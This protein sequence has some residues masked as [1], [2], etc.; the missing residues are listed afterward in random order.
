MASF[1]NM[2]HDF[3]KPS[4]HQ[5]DDLT[6]NLKQVAPH[7]DAFDLA[8][9][10]DANGDIRQTKM[11]TFDTSI[12]QP[13]KDLL[14]H[15]FSLVQTDSDSGDWEPSGQNGMSAAIAKAK[16][17]D[18][19]AEDKADGFSASNDILSAANM[20]QE[21]SEL[22]FYQEEDFSGEDWT[23]AG[24]TGLSDAITKARQDT[25]DDEIRHDGLKGNGLLSAAGIAQ[26]EDEEEDLDLVSFVQVETSEWHPQDSLGESISKAR[27][28]EEEARA[29]NMDLEGNT[30]LSAAGIHTEEEKEVD[31]LET[32]FIQEDASWSPKGQQ[33]QKD[34][35]EDEEPK[36]DEHSVTKIVKQHSHDDMEGMNI[37]SAVGLGH[38]LR[39]GDEAD[40]IGRVDADDFDFSLD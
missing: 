15:A 11:A 3:Q 5:Y 26:K 7:A 40:D 27:Q 31:P 4:E 18:E 39:K 17:D 13:K 16:A 22:L 23:P 19:A 32:L 1:D 2:L 8:L 34:D 6:E 36:K 24:Q 12:D 35:E 9:R 14:G 30:L 29:T 37:L 28:A 33:L 38:H 21:A 20:D 10:P 25:Y